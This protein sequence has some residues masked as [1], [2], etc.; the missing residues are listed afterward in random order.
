MQRLLL[1]HR[2]RLRVRTGRSAAR[3]AARESPIGSATWRLPRPTAARPA[4]ACRMGRRT[5]RLSSARWT[6]RSLSAR[7]PG[8]ARRP[9][10]G[11]APPGAHHQGEGQPRRRGL[12][13][14]SGAQGGRLRA[15]LPHRLRPQRL[16]RRGECSLTCGGGKQNQHK[17]ID[18]AP[19]HGGR[20]CDPLQQQSVDCD[21]QPC[22]IDC[23][24][25][26]WSEWAGAP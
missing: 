11:R 26:V 9:R 4:T 5:A 10:A 24:V 3:R 18:T 25:S 19:E 12:P 6:A 13:G 20:S 22:P 17:S 23:E 15:A 1:P 16:V 7:T 2:L 21:T 8:S 14:Q